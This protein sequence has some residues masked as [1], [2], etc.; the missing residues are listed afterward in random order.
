MH[1]STADNSPPTGTCTQFRQSHPDGHDAILSLTA[2]VSPG[3]Y[4]SLRLAFD[5]PQSAEK[6]VKCNCVNQLFRDHLAT[7]RD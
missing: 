5:I 1:G 3:R 4:I 2:H 6:S 7:N